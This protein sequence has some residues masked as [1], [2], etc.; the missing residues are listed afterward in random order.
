MHGWVNGVRSWLSSLDEDALRSLLTWHQCLRGDRHAHTPGRTAR[1]TPPTRRELHTARVRLAKAQQAQLTSIT[2]CGLVWAVKALRDEYGFPERALNDPTLDELLAMLR[3]LDPPLARC[4]LH[5]M[6]LPGTSRLPVGPL[7]REHEAALQA[8]AD[9]APPPDA[10]TVGPGFDAPPDGA[11]EPLTNTPSEC[12]DAAP[13]TAPSPDTASTADLPASL[14]RLRRSGERLAAGLRAA[15]DAVETGLLP[16]GAPADGITAWTEERERL[17]AALAA[18]GVDWGPG[19]GYA[20]AEAGLTRLREARA[21][22]IDALRRKAARYAELLELADDEDEA[23]DLRRHLERTEAQLRTLDGPPPTPGAPERPA[24]PEEATGPPEAAGREEPAAPEG[25]AGPGRATAPVD[26]EHA[27]PQEPAAPGAPAEPSPPGPD[28]DPDAGSPAGPAV[29]EPTGNGPSG[30]PVGPTETGPAASPVGPTEH[31]TGDAAPLAGRAAD[32]VRAGAS[33][34]EA[35]R[36][37]VEPPSPAPVPTRPGPASAPRKP[38]TAAPTEQ[39]P[40]A[41]PGQVTA[42]G[43]TPTAVPEPQRAAV[44]AQAGAPTTAPPTAAPRPTAVPAQRPAAVPEPASAGAPGQAAAS[45]PVPAPAPVP[46]EDEPWPRGVEAPDW[47]PYAPWD[48]GSEPPVARL[49]REGRSAEAYWMTVASRESDVRARTLA[50]AAAAFACVS[51]SEATPVQMAHE[52]DPALAA[53]DRE[54]HLVALAAALRTGLTTRWPHGL[55]SGF[56]MPSG[57]SGAWQH[58]LNVLVAAVRDGRAFEPG[59]LQG[60]VEG[61]QAATREEIGLTARQLLDDLPR[62]KMKYQRASQVLQHLLGP[63]GAVRHALNEVIEWSGQSPA[64][65]TGTPGFRALGEQLWR[66]EDIDRLIEDTDALFRTSKQAKEPITAGALRQLHTAC[67]C[68]G[69][70]LMRAEAAHTASRPHQGVSDRG[71]PELASVLRDVACEPAPAGTG[72]AALG[73]LRAWLTGEQVRPADTAADRLRENGGPVPPADALLRLPDLPRDA[74]G[75]PDLADPRAAR[76]IAALLVPADAEYA[77]VRY[78][79]DGDLHLAR[80]LIAAVES[81]PEEYGCTDPEWGETAARRLAQGHED[82]RREVAEHHRAA[83]GLLAQMRTLN[84]LAADQEREFVG[85]LQEFADGEE[86]GRYRFAVESLRALEA[87]LVTLVEDYTR[88]LRENLAQLR[89]RPDQ[90]LSA[91]DHERIARLIDEGDTVTA[92]EFL[93][94]ATSHTPLPERGARYDDGSELAAFLTGV[95]APGAPKAGGE[96]V[97]ADWWAKHYGDPASSPTPAATNGLEAWAALCGPRG[98]RGELPQHLSRLLRLLGLDVSPGQ[99]VAERVALGQG[100]RRFKV[101]ARVAERPGYV[102]ALGSRASSYTVLLVWEEQPADGP[103]AHLEDADVGANIVLY[104]HPLGLEGRRGLAESARSF[105]QQALVVDS[106]VMGWMAA[107]APGSFRSLQR[108]TLPWAAYNPYTPFVAGL[109]PPEVFYGRDEEMREVMGR[110][111]GMFLYGGRQLGKSALLRRVA[112]IFPSRADTHVAVYLDLLKAEI[113]HAEAPDRIWSRLVEDLKRKGVFNNKMSEQAGPDVVVRNIQAWLEEDDTRRILVLADEAD[114]FLNTDSRRAY[115]LGSESTFPNVMHFQRLMEQTERRFKIV[116][117]GLHQVQRFGHL[118][119]VSTVHG[120]PDVLV[121]PLGTQAAVRLVTEP[122]SAL[123]HFFERP[124]LVWR[125]LAITNYQ[126]NLVQIFCREL[127]R[128]LHDRPYAFSDG[129]VRITEADV[130]KVAASETVRRQIAERLR[131]TINLEDRYRVLALVIALLSL[132]DGYRGDYSAGELLQKARE[133][134]PEGFEMLSAKQAQIFLTEMVGLGLLIQLGDRSRFAV[135]S[136]NVVNMLGTREE[137]ELELRETEFGLPYDYNPHAARRLLGRDA[138]HVQTYSPLTEEQLHETAQSG[139]SLIGTTA[140]HRPELVR[141]AVTAFAEN[142][143]VDVVPYTHGEDLTALLK[144]RRRKAHV[145]MA[146]LR[147]A[148]PERLREAVRSMLVHAGPAAD[149]LVRQT[150]QRSGGNENRSVVVV[151]DAAALAGLAADDGHEELAVR[152]LRPERW[153]ADALRA[154]SECPFVS[155]EDRYRLVAA[156]GGWPRWMEAA[157]TD[158]SVHGATLD[159]AVERIRALIAGTRNI[160]E[161]LRLSGLDLGDLG[162]LAAWTGY[163]EEGQGL[164][165]DDV[166]AAVELSDADTDAWLQHLGLLGV[167]DETPEGFAVE[168]VTYRA[169]RSRAAAGEK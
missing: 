128:V 79:G 49:L 51:D 85:R 45:A 67:R 13:V 56:V 99:V 84:Q 116:F 110:E 91:G 32:R 39:P 162:L 50:F 52:L 77:L 29:K 123:G 153:T 42:S 132:A 136:P 102:A 21:E 15:A 145:I 17:A 108:V 48:T 20:D 43:P 47:D 70:L 74:L 78:L 146:D 103:L 64:Q 90:P 106:A 126:A 12:E 19:L 76:R 28:G 166:A 129:P 54:A 112:E 168:P 60:S 18:E 104:L 66:A 5:G 134:W 69:E 118:S 46:V 114:A 138:R 156:T 55:V 140:L 151:A 34:I 40:V 154:W 167:L 150:E 30:S 98:R 96:G 147:G 122:M 59:M 61:Q 160:D 44:P 155:R 7:A 157:V 38:A 36:R 149:R 1:R 71:I 113:G 8:A 4:A 161:H 65:Y 111:G 73:L 89:A 120:G 72:G 115:R 159:S 83:A 82:W 165:R 81:E 75:D 22:Q 35:V 121:G 124:E 100:M 95:T 26:P 125:I 163:V 6:L 62:R 53:Q 11:H 164:P 68:V 148:T 109:V 144:G 117:A 139:V 58:L 92:Q 27:A 9:S 3:V 130:Q 131:F 97:E 25:A 37:A 33:A 169:V 2:A 80:A 16:E 63:S 119:N 152:W 143:G 14:V 31:G 105:A 10:H 107:R 93:A 158:V 101:R 127:V 135:R 87:E 133:A 141:R 137:L 24:A 94:L 88:Q 86:S 23:S 142:R 57:L 41:V